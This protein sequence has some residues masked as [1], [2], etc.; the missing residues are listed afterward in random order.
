[1]SPS[2]HHIS[3]IRARPA[4]TDIAQAMTGAIV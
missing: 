1:M 2:R 3:I 4:R